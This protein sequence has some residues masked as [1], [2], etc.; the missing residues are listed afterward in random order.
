MKLNKH[1]QAKPNIAGLTSQVQQAEM[2][3][4]LAGAW[5]A[6]KPLPVF[7]YE[8]DEYRAS[9]DFD[10]TRGEW[11]CRKTS[12]PSN[13]VQEL[14]GGLTEITMGLSHGQA[15]VFTEDVAAEPQEQELEK[16]ANRRLQAILE[17][18]E[19]YENG[20]LYSELQDYLSESQQDEIYDSIRLSLTARQLQFNPKNVAFVFDALSNAGG[21]LA[22]LIEIAQRN[23]AE[24]EA[25]AQAQ[26]EAA[27]LEAEHQV[28]VEAIHPTRDRRLQTRTTPASRAYVELGD[29]NGGIVLNISET[30]MAVAAADL[31]VVGDYLPRI[32]FQLP[33]SRQSIEVS[34]QI[35]WL[36]EAKKGAGIRFVD[37]T[38]EARNQISNWIASE[39]PAPEFQQLPKPLGRD[40]QPLEISSRKSRRIFSN[41]SVRDEEAAARYAGMFPSERTY[42][43]HT[44]PVDEIKAQQGPLL[45]PADSHTDAGNSVV[46]PGAEISI[47]DFPQSLKA[48]FPSERAKKF[49]RE[50]IKSFIPELT[51]GL[52]PAPVESLIPAT[53]ENFPTKPIGSVFPEQDQTSSPELIVHTASQASETVTP[54]ILDANPLSLVEDPQEKVH[55]HTPVAGLGPQVRTDKVE[56]SGDRIKDSPSRLCV[57]EISGFQVAALVILFAVISLT[58]GL[59]VGRGPLGKRLRDTQKSILAVDAPSPALPNR[60]GETTSRTSTPPA[61]NTFST[62]AVNTPAAKTEESGSESPSAQSLNARKADSANRVRSTGPSSAVTSRSIINSDNSSGADKLDDATPSEE[63]SKESTRDSESF[64]KVPSTDSNSSPTIESKPSAN[65][66]PS[67][68][69]NGSTG[70]IA[71]NAPPPASPRP[72]HSPKAVG[73]I[74]G[75]LRNP[76]PRRVT[77][78]TG[79][80]PHPSPPSAILVTA[81]AHGSKPFRLFFPERPIA[82]SSSFAM[83]SQLSVLVSPEPGP[84]VAHKPARLQAGE[85]VSYVWPRYPRPGDRYGSAETIKVRTTIGQLGQVLDIKLVSGSISLLPATMGAIRRWRYKPTLLN[86]RPVQAQQDVT[87]EFRPPQYWLHVPAQH[88][89]HN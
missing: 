73:P 6:L 23:K 29:T 59:T 56:S 72:A 8:T 38:A 36:A 37:L 88:P 42:A 30:G 84:A 7:K 78:A 61:A 70:L 18:R 20:A 28:R 22:T 14:R 57:L 53:L 66:E 12:L 82:A 62:R 1:E 4:I 44:T 71:R 17:W 75:A 43:K 35:V 16:D 64:A 50:P 41:P 9:I 40:N 89:S 15:E 51:E 67:P 2:R 13:K 77:P 26:A 83:T 25:D 49:A 33:S 27:A 34:A 79:A 31:L 3:L 55:H 39:R 47:G 76:A 19:N 65:P 74:S 60:P 10:K 87:I 48:S 85:L 80:A 5:P 69:R 58:V 86:K 81:P 63:K 24:Q 68:E 45:I 46:G 21:R 52:T 54:E 11:V 32:R